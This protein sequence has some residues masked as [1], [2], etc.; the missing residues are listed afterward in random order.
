[1]NST[2]H[3]PQPGR[4]CA[5]APPS[6]DADATA[7]EKTLL[8]TGLA[9]SGTSML[10]ALVQAAGVWLG[11]HVY[12]PINEDAEITQMLRARDLTRLDALIRAAERQDAALGLQ[13]AGSASVPAAR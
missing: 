9:R 4:D 11:D 7:A 8:I 5:V 2:Q 3:D 10:A 1:M 6:A 12:Q 13:D